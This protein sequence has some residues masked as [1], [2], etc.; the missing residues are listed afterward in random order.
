MFERATS[1]RLFRGCECCIAP[2][3]SAAAGLSAGQFSAAPTMVAMGAGSVSAE[4]GLQRRTTSSALSRID[5]HHHVAPPKWLTDVLGRDLLQPATRNW[6]V[7]KSLEDMDQGGVAAAAVSVTN[8]GLWFGDKEQSRRLAR[9]SNDFM[10]KLVQDRPTR[11]A[12]F[13]AMPMPDVDG[14]LTEIAYALDTL[15]AD[16]I[17]L[18]TSYRDIW[19]GN[20]LFVPVMEELNRRKAL[21]FVHP[22][23]AACCMNLIPDV[24][25]GVIEYGTDTTRAILGILFSGAAVRFP[26][27]RFIWSHAGGSAPFFAGRIEQG[28]PRLKDHATRL[29]NGA[30]HEM[31][32]FF[33]DIAGAANPGALASLMTLVASSQVLFGTDYPSGMSRDIIAGLA[34]IGFSD[35]DI[36]AINQ[37]NALKLLPRLS[38]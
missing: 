25:P 5:V 28:L 23:A 20:P 18:F 35:S 27:I 26:D 15:K 1:R 37:G 24:V 19:L 2:D 31:K 9:D 10:A 17:G 33:Y 12:F 14:T 30:I 16:G 3:I 8:P 36:A 22:T 29:P 38:A 34:E 6:S 13:A 7:E 32:K 4:P 21:V 11:F